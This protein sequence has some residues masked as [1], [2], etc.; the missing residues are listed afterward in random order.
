MQFYNLKTFVR[1]KLLTS[2]GE[3]GGFIYVILNGK[4]ALD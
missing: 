3:K 4:V 2:L 1:K